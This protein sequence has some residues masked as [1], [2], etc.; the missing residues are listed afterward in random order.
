MPILRS[1][2]QEIAWAWRPFTIATLTPASLATLA[3]RSF[4]RMPPVPSLLLPLHTASICGVS[5][6]TVR[7]RRGRLP[8]GT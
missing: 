1:R 3:A 4:E 2:A 6:R 7:S 5:L 8:L